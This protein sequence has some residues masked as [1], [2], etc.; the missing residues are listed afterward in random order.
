MTEKTS[1]TTYYDLEI[2]ALIEEINK[3]KYNQI[4]LQFPDGLK[5]YGKEVIDEIKEKTDTEVF[6][7]FGTC[8]GACD[9]PVHLK[10]LGFELC[11][12]WGHSAYIKKKEM[13]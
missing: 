5:Y 7:Y 12:Q 13:W 10:D 3:H 9:I 1:H 2:G 4:L 8:F 11:V 6:T